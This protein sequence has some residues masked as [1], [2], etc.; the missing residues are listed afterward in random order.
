MCTLLVLASALV[1]SGCATTGG[2]VS[3]ED[4]VRAVLGQWK[5]GLVAADADKIMATYS[6]NFTAQDTTGFKGGADKAGLRKF[7]EKSIKNGRYEGVEINLDDVDIAIEKGVAT[8]YPI[9][10]TV[11]EGS[12]T[13]KLILTKE[14]AGWLITDMLV[15]M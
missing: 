8:V 6:E 11:P 1:I 10:Y 3:D 13:I 12:I 4:Q 14:Q 5:D 2:G 9:G 15:E 7:V